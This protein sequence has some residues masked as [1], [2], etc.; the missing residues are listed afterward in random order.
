MYDIKIIAKGKEQFKDLYS[1]SLED[2]Q[3]LRE[4]DGYRQCLL[5]L[6]ELIAASVVFPH[7]IRSFFITVSKMILGELKIMKNIDDK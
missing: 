2:R 6:N 1:K 7:G 3:K 5:D 4:T